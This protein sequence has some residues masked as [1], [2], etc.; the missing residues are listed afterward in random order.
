M[1]W[2][3][4]TATPQIKSQFGHVSTIKK[5]RDFLTTRYSDKGRAIRYKVF[6]DLAHLQQHLEQSIHDFLSEIQPFWDQMSLSEP[7]QDSTRDVEKFTAY[8]N[9]LQIYQLFMTLNVKFEVVRVSLL[10]TDP[11]YSLEKVITEVSSDETQLAT[12]KV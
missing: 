4:S 9:G 12:L 5:V 7:D 2:I 8:K 3:H 11:L 1:T 6:C 10:Y